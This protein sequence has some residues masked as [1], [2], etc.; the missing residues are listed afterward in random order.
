MATVVGSAAAAP[1]RIDA[2]DGLRSVAFI[3]V[4]VHHALGAPL[5][6]MGVDLFFVMSGFLITGILVDAK[7]RQSP[8]GYFA[9]FF[10]RRAL[11]IIPPYYLV[12]AVAFATVL[13]DRQSEAPWFVFFASNV[14]DAG[15]RPGLDAF[16]SPMWSLA[17]E[18][19]FYLA[20]P[21]VVLL[22]SPR[23]MVA[24]A[25]SLLV[26]APAAR[27]LVTVLDVGPFAAYRLTP[28][29]IDLLAAG[30]LLAVAWRTHRGLVVRAR[31]P[32][33]ALAAAALTA[34]LVIGACVPSFRVAGGSLLFNTLG[35][36]LCAVAAC[37]A[38][39]FAVTASPGELAH[40]AL[41][42]RVP[43]LLGTVSYG[44]YLVHEGV[45]VAV[46]GRVAG[47]RPLVAL[48]ALA[49]TFAIAWAS[50]V[51]LERPLLRWGTAHRPGRAP[52]ATPGRPVAGKLSAA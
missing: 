28:C 46:A 30:A 22:T 31:R 34:M 18:E 25:A 52:V 17:V 21:A 33:L 13:R 23:A 3:A 11:R 4:F 14:R 49:V 37:G 7:K 51:C 1:R 19:Q 43:V 5:L 41:T 40:R 42:H 12:L 32:A 45:I 6:W 26:L 39:V 8:G 50:W 10:R 2:L 27:A 9:T 36:S 38:F 44:M 29:R 20:W 48:L 24:L 16:V 35:Y 47:P 15:H